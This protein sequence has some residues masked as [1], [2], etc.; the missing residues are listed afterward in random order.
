M[1][2]DVVCQFDP[3]RKAAE[4]IAAQKH[5]IFLVLLLVQLELRGGSE[6]NFAPFLI[7]QEQFFRSLYNG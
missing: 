6:H 2:F 4:T 1:A 7:A 5:L 3:G